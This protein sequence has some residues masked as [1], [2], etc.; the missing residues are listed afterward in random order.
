M[1]GVPTSL[2]VQSTAGA[3]SVLVPSSRDAL[4]ATGA[5]IEVEGSSLAGLV[6]PRAPLN[7]GNSGTTMRLL[8]G[9]LA[10]RPFEAVLEGDASLTARPME[11]IATP[12]REMGASVE[13][14]DGH[15]PVTIRGGPLHGIRWRVDPPSAQVKGALLL[16]GLQADGMTTVEEAMVTRDH[17]ERALEALGGPIE[18]GERMVSL[19]RF[20]H[21]GFEGDVPGDVSSAAFLI[22]AAAL[23]GSD[24][25]VE[26]VGLN[27]SR[28]AFVTVLRRMGV[29]VTL[30]PERTEMGEPVGGLIT[31]PTT[32]RGTTVSSMELPLVIDEV[33]VLS[34]VAACA[35]GES[36]FEGAGELRV[37]ETDRLDGVVQGIHALGGDAAIEADALVVGGGGLRGG[38]VDS[39]GDHRLAM[40]FAVA[41]LAAGAESVVEGMGS[42]AVSFP[43]FITTLGKLGARI[44]VER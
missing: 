38:R 4:R 31:R 9:V 23:T 27:P 39:G 10:S 2:D 26:G 20:Q 24:I 21:S 42:A 18:R 30:T 6:E 33:P 17:T 3:L 34:M 29:D 43:G 11:R 22:G 37:K 16:A 28:L 1:R 44:E 13:T 12:L 15:S 35:E 8:A 40:A 32:L 41:A 19:G 5:S 25:E 7:C 14:S 36:R